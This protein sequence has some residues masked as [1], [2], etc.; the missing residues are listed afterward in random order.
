MEAGPAGQWF[1][2]VASIPMDGWPLRGVHSRWLEGLV[3]DTDRAV[4]R[5]VRAQHQAAAA[6]G[7][8]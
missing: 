5:T 2:A 6:I 7:R 4:I 8:P 1:H 3:T